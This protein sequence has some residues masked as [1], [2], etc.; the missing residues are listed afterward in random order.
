MNPK[1]QITATTCRKI[2]GIGAGIAE[3]K[4]KSRPPVQ[5][6][7]D[8]AGGSDHCVGAS[9][10]AGNHATGDLGKRGVF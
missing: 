8:E 5:N 2:E 10:P 7:P 4:P 9:G 3:P 6:L 1:R